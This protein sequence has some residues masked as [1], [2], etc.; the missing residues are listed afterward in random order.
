VT[1]GSR[2]GIVRDLLSGKVDD[3][4]V[5]LTAYAAQSAAAQDVPGAL[6]DLAYFALAQ[7]RPERYVAAPLSLLDARR[8]V[9]GFADAVLAS[10]NV[11]DFGQIEDDLFRWARTV[12]STPALRTVLVDRDMAVE[13]RL[14]LTSSLLSNKVA[15]ASLSLALYVI[16][17]GRPRDVVGTLDY[18]VDFVAKARDWRVARVRSARALDGAARESL[19]T[20]VSALTGTSVDLQVTEDD[21]LLGGVLVEVGDLRLDAT[22][23]GRLE[24]LR[25]TVAAGS[26]PTLSHNETTRNK[27]S[28]R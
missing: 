6:G 9:A 1:A 5:N 24:A 28:E 23:K 27:G 16:E 18:L 15:P 19:V 13:A 3:T 20:A 14:E 17:G 4:V 2:A 26:G 25:D 8:R 12:E 7:T 21:T 10:L 22:T 11:A